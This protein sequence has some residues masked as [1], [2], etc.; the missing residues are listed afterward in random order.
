MLTNTVAPRVS[1]VHVSVS[2]VL[3]SRRNRATAWILDEAWPEFASPF[4]AEARQSNDVVAVPLTNRHFL[5]AATKRAGVECG[6]FLT[7]RLKHRRHAVLRSI[8][9]TRRRQ[10]RQRF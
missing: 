5:A 4:V 1:K 10:P 8:E 3:T 2:A 9:V 7:S 6:R